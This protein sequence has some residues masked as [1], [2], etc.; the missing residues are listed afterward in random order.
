RNIDKIGKGVAAPVPRGAVAESTAGTAGAYNYIKNN[1]CPKWSKYYLLDSI[2]NR[3]I[4]NLW[5]DSV[6]P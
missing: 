4:R 6:E 1:F 2:E 5:R 3:E